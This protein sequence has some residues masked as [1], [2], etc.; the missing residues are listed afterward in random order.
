MDAPYACNSTEHTLARRGFLG[1]VAGVTASSL[2]GGGLNAFAGPQATAQLTKQNKRV[3]VIFLSGG[4]SQLESWDPKPGTDTGGPFRA[5]PTSVKG[6]HI[7]ELLPHTA[8]QMKHLA[9]VRSINTKEGDHGKG[10]YC[11]ER[12]RRR[13]DPGD[14]PHLGAVT[15]KALANLD[16]PLPG[17]IQ[18]T[19]GGKGSRRNDAAYLGPKYAGISLGDG[20][21]PSYSK[22]PDDISA[23]ADKRRNDFRRRANERLLQRRRTAFT[24]LY[25]QSYEQA[26]EMMARRDVFDVTK[27]SEK[28]SKR[29]GEHDFGRHCLLAR[30]LLENGITFVQVS[31]TNYDTHHENFNFHIEQVGEFDKPFATLIDDL[32]QRGMLDSTLVLVMS[33]FGRTP[34]INDRYGRDHWGNAWSMVLGGC[35][36]Q[37][38]AV[39]GKTNK[40]GT[41]VADG[42]VDHRHLFH[43][44]LSATGL[45]P[46]SSFNVG[47][48]K[49]L[50]ADPSGYAIEELLV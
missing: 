33:E 26:H 28:D 2:L 42:E 3:L 49:M 8:K 19:P 22:R 20:K 11:M 1:G 23:E 25:A 50:L 16:N 12:G 43:T 17:H 34:R 10:R 15:A 46:T 27:E 36:I 5:I 47:G 6:L 32:H 39:Y 7:S 44:Y 24:D 29:Y 4:V 31:H 14:Y 21:P 9:V 41:A 37:Q 13:T 48:R 35:G 38:G 30:R 40:N 45:D 18:I